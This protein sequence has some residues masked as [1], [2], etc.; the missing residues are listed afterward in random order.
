MKEYII[1]RI[2][3]PHN[4]DYIVEKSTPVVCFGDFYSAKFVTIGINPSSSEFTKKVRNERIVLEG[5]DRRL[6]DL[7]FLNRATASEL[8]S[9]EIEEIWFGCLNYFDGPYYKWFSKMQDTVLT[10][11]GASYK[12]RTAVHLDLIQWA[13]DPLWEV[14]LKKDPETAKRHLDLD[15]PFLKKQIQDVSANLF[16]L[17]GMPV[18]E[19]LSDCF[20]LKSI[21]KTKVKGK[22]KQYE[23]FVGSW[24]DSLVLGTSM[25][26]SDSWTSNEHR[27]YLSN[28]ISDVFHSRI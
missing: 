3:R 13:T 5:S 24:Q 19:N 27:R 22:A 23:L 26:I 21:G 10:P 16:F 15:L 7:Y 18:V 4:L 6:I 20:N 11:L 25:N 17:T 12:E 14:M 9:R 2:S 8:T 28:W 1:E